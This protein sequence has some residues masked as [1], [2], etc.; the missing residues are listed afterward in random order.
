M[1]ASLDFSM[2][3]LKAEHWAVWGYLWVG[4]SVCS[5]AVLKAEKTVQR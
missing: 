4:T 1:A 5:M 3:D 2:A